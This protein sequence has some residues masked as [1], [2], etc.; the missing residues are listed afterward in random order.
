L[1]ALSDTE[2][3]MRIVNEDTNIIGIFLNILG[4]GYASFWHGAS[5]QSIDYVRDVPAHPCTALIIHVANLTESQ[6]TTSW[7]MPIDRNRCTII[8]WAY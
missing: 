7:A 6:N 4:T 5:L 1:Q 8:A 3:F 2:I